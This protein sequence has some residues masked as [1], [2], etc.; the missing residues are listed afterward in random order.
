MQW[1]PHRAI[2]NQINVEFL[3]YPI[4]NNR[5]CII[6]CVFQLFHV[7]FW[8]CAPSRLPPPYGFLLKS[9]LITEMIWVSGGITLHRMVAFFTG[10]S[11]RPVGHILRIKMSNNKIVLNILLRPAVLKRFSI[12]SVTTK[13]YTKQ[14][15]SL[16]S[17]LRDF[18][19]S[20]GLPKAW[21]NSGVADGA[22]CTV[23]SW[24]YS[25]KWMK[26]T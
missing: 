19:T 7:V 15:R 4:S 11:G 3:R 9:N 10:V 16:W 12:S 1:K 25:A 14:P 5:L 8:I 13:R 18:Y 20:I 2:W 24:D 22:S 17:K 21:V 26:D 23:A 6:S